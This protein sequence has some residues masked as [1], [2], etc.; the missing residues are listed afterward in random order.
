MAYS[1][2]ANLTVDEL[3]SLIKETVTETILE[4]FGNPDEGLELRQEEE[5]L[6]RSLA[7]TPSNVK[8]TS[9]QEVAAKLGLE[10]PTVK[11]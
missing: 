9:A 2:V 3:K 11:T 7:Q 6:H 4:I 10:K 1:S 5:R 8:M